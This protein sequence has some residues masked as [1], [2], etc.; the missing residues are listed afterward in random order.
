MA[1]LRYFTAFLHD[2][3]CKMKNVHFAHKMQSTVITVIT[4]YLLMRI[5]EITC[6]LI[7]ERG[8][9]KRENFYSSHQ[10]THSQLADSLT[11]CKS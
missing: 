1:Q 2:D 6:L 8:G 3:K 5:T 10:I 11:K 4:G 7:K 9:R